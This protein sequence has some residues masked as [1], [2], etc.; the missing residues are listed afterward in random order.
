MKTHLNPGSFTFSA[1]LSLLGCLLFIGNGDKPSRLGK[2]LLTMLVLLKVFAEEIKSTND[3]IKLYGKNYLKAR[4]REDNEIKEWE[5]SFHNGFNKQSEK[6]IEYISAVWNV[7]T[8]GGESNPALDYYKAEL[9]KTKSNLLALLRAGKMIKNSRS[10]QNMN[11]VNFTIVS[12]YIHM[13]NNRLGILI[14][15]ESYLAHLISNTLEK[16]SRPATVK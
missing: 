6:L 14:S 5:T 16:I 9:I 12:S 10:V 8:E 4:A 7:L 3:W 15:E 1:V 13:M 2:G 11:M